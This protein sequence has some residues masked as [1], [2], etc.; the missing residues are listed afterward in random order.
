MTLNLS[1]L[2]FMTQFWRVVSRGLLLYLEM[3]RVYI[4]FTKKH[5]SKDFIHSLIVMV[6]M[7]MLVLMLMVRVL[8]GA[9]K[10]WF[11]PGCEAWC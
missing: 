8:F 1:R 7:V 5:E 3:I 10:I 2:F 6:K 9:T 4:H 11:L